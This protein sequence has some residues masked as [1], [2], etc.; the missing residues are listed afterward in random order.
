[1]GTVMNLFELL[2]GTADRQG[3][4]PA[5]TDLG[6]G[7]GLD[8]SG[9]LAAAERVARTLR[10]HGVEPG[11]RV[12][13]VAENTLAYVPTAFG[14]L[15]SG[16]CLVPIGLTLRPNEMAAV[17]ATIDVNA[18]VRLPGDDLV[19]EWVDRGREP[20]P[21]FL[22]TNAAFVRFTSGTTDEQKGVILSHA[23]VLARMTAADAVWHLSS[24]DRV[25]WTLSLAYHFAATITA[26]VRAGA[27]ILLCRDTLPG[28]LTEACARWRPT[29]LYGSPVQFQR[30]ARAVPRARLD[31][32]R[33]ALST[34]AALP[35]PIAVAFEAAFDVPLGQAYGLI[36][37]GIPAINT[38]AGGLAATSVGPAVP[39]YRISILAEGGGGVEPGVPG[40]VMLQGSGLFS[41]YY[42]PWRPVG[43]VLRDGWFPTGDIGMLD[44]DGYLTLCGR[45]K[46]M[47]IIAGMKLFPEEVE[48]VLDRQPGIRESRVVGRPHPQLGEV[49]CA[50]L[51]VEHGTTPDLRALAAACA[52]ELSSYK[53]P[54]EFRIVESIPRS[55]AGKIRRV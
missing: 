17:L 49:P 28:G 1:M 46:S 40:E 50:E 37:A 45:K 15:A 48:R 54:V 11:Q 25:L 33:S 52:G 8:Y 12:A 4:R 41:G 34:A 20:S 32:V 26:Y 16:A 10:T 22:D 24:E 13:L 21:G 5:V 53:V 42:S 27:H 36:E 43:A 44:G 35:E 18:V 55:A 38:R 9:V 23:N 7:R 39:G 29:L 47:I 30:M 51:V 2:V 6:S 3:S 14:I 19:L 31:S